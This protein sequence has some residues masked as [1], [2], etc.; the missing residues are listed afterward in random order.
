M[1]GGFCLQGSGHVARRERVLAE[2]FALLPV[3]A[4]GFRGLLGW[5]RV[6]SCG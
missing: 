3:M 5:R 2:R 1:A 4:L 6:V